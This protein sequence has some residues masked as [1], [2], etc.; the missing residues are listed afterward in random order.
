MH[1]SFSVN[2]SVDHTSALDNECLCRVQETRDVSAVAESVNQP[3][4]LPSVSVTGES[5][6]RLACSFSYIF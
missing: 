5:F 6:A 3:L 4:S 1:C 2:L